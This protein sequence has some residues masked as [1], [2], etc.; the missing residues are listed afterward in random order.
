MHFFI[1]FLTWL[2]I[3]GSISLF[4]FFFLSVSAAEMGPLRSAFCYLVWLQWGMVC[5]LRSGSLVVGGGQQRALLLGD[6]GVRLFGRL[7]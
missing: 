3:K 4:F 2:C 5:M 7:L 1:I 6:E